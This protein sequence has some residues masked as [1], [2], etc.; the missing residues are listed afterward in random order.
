MEYLNCV[1]GVFLS[2]M[3]VRKQ[4][5][6]LV[7]AAVVFL[8]AHGR[9]AVLRFFTVMQRLTMANTNEGAKIPR[10]HY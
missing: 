2:R 9:V 7:V 4:I 1:K 6:A 8:L 3:L 5:G 10:G